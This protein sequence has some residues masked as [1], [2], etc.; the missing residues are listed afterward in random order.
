MNYEIITNEDLYKKKY[1]ID[2]LEKNIKILNKIRLVNTQKLTAYFCV[3]YLLDNNI[4]S[5]DEDS[6]ILDAAYILNSQPHISDEEWE[7]AI[8]KIYRNK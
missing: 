2:I 7:E 8:Q 1:S 5:G 3:R 6:Y 4:E